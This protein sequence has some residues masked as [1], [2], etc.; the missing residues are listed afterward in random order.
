MIRI[1]REIQCLPYAGFF[2]YNGDFHDYAHYE[3]YEVEINRADGDDGGHGYLEDHGGDIDAGVGDDN[4]ADFRNDSGAYLGP[5]EEPDQF[6][7]VHA[8]SDELRLVQLTV[9][10]DVQLREDAEAE[11]KD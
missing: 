4:D 3:D 9:V 7:V 8:A 11:Q 6:T 2:L 5:I 10:I 1:G